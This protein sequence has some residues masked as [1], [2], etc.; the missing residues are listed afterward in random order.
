MRAAGLR[1][2]LEAKDPGLRA[3]KAL[4]SVSLATVLGF[5]FSLYVVGEDQ[6]AFSGAS[7]ASLSAH[8]PKLPASRAER[9]KTYA[10]AL[11]AGIVLV[12]LGTLL[13]VNT[14]AAAAGMLVV[15]FA[16]AYAGVGGPRLIGAATGLQLLY[17]LPSFPPYAPSRWGGG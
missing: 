9:T 6:M 5:Y 10:G 12:T 1:T 16:V 11:L 3:V 2:W 8:C 7:A 14:W 17:I 13:A 4:C 15:G